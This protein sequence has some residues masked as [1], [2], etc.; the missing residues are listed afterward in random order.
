MITAV[1]ALATAMA[2]V[3]LV[4]MCMVKKED[5][6]AAA[7]NKVLDNM[8]AIT[9]LRAKDAASRDKL[10]DYYG[11]AASVM[12]I[13]L[14][15]GNEKGIAKLEEQNALLKKGCLKQVGIFA[16]PGYVLLRRFEALNKSGIHKVILTKSTELYGKKHAENKTRQ[17][18]AKLL[19]YPI[20]GVSFSF[21]LGASAMRYSSAAGAAIL[22]AG[23]ALMLI[24]IYAMYDE[25][26]DKTN[27]RRAA[28]AR[29]FPNMASKLALLVTS[30]MIMAKAWKETAYSA[31]S[32]LYREM[33]KTSEELD[34]LVS[35]ETAYSAF[36]NRCNTKETSKL[37]S[38][39]M[40]NLSKGNAEIG[41]LL[42]EL[43]KEAWQ[44]RRHTAKRDSEKANS[45]LIIPAMLLFLAILLIIMAPVV[46]NFANF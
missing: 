13:F 5:W 23:T 16:M 41:G 15:R 32:E 40:Q 10:A 3:W 33:R 27:R 43:A 22:S 36:I 38:A 1:V 29:Q 42:R 4:L 17:L 30:G 46:M 25:V 19:S 14:G 39:I 24:L 9:K 26:S 11:I 35:P 7:Y 28:I 12:K 45:K 8:D 18:M 31:D 21:A 44:E 6:T 20:A 37:A 34:N 2:F